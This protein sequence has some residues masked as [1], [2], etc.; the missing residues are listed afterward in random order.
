M[1]IGI[2]WICI[3]VLTAAAFNVWYFVRSFDLLRTRQLMANTPT[4]KI[5]SL[6]VGLVEIK[7]KAVPY[8]GVYE[9]AISRSECIYYEYLVET[10]GGNVT[11]KGGPGPHWE[12]VKSASTFNNPFYVED[13]TGKILVNPKNAI[14]FLPVSFYM[15]PFWKRKKDRQIVENFYFREFENIDPNKKKN[16]QRVEILRNDR[17]HFRQDLKKA[18]M[19]R[20]SE[21][22]IKP[23]DNLYVMG[24]AAPKKPHISQNNNEDSLVITMGEQ[25]QTFVISTFS[26]E[27]LMRKQVAMCMLN[28][29]GSAALSLI[30]ILWIIY[31]IMF[32]TH[33]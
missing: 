9:S 11:G 12:D 30:S 20:Y 1:Y 27:A 19:W 18:M 33:K 17:F 3:V 13:D 25:E 4:S 31:Y 29:T 6:A 24:T 15:P 10:I 5:R 23:G 14:F 32:I 16:Q 2:I 22:I 26:E 8:D 28:I 7:G 21:R